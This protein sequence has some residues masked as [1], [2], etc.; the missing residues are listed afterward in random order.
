MLALLIKKGLTYVNESRIRFAEAANKAFL[1]RNKG[2]FS[3]WVLER[4]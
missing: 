2:S 1:P 4:I 3:R